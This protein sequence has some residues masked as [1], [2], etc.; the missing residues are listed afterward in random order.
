MGYTNNGFYLW[1][2]SSAL[3]NT[4]SA[5]EYRMIV[6]DNGGTAIGANMGG[7]Y[8]PSAPLHVD[9]FINGGIGNF[10]YFSYNGTC[11]VQGCASGTTDVSIYATNRIRASEFNAFSDSRIKHIIGESSANQDLATLMKLI[12]TDYTHIDV[13]GKG[14]A[15]KKGFIA[16]QIEAE[17]PEAV[18]Q[19]R[20][21]IPNVY[22]VPPHIQYIQESQILEVTTSK[23]HEFIS[24]DMVKLIGDKTY[25]LP[26]EVKDAHTF[27]VKNWKYGKQN[28]F[29]F[30]KEVSD[31]RAVDY[32]RIFTLNVSATQA[33]AKK[34]QEL[35]KE[36]AQLKSEVRKI[37]AIE[38][39]IEA[40]NDKILSPKLSTN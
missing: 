21:F 20:D 32:D 22:E 6:H 18:S 19:S 25:E 29:V 13:V 4:A 36:N 27:L 30:G 17:F 40:L 9:G 7:A 26:V 31:F 1:N 2:S 15:S 24:G 14:A 33:L 39:Q 5:A 11:N 12:V 8:T 23:P 37:H 3:A 34:V 16:Q 38:H 28:I 35:E 10:A